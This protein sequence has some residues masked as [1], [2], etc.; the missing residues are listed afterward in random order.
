MLKKII[1]APDSF[2]GTMSSIEVCN[3]IEQG[4]KNINPDIATIKIPIAD[5]GEGTVD[6]FLTAVE[7]KKV[8]VKVKDPLFRD[9]DSFY[10]LLQ[11]GT[12]AVIEMAAASGL[13]LVG[14]DQNPIL[15]S[16]FGTGQLL[17][18]A[19]EHGCTRI[20]I[21]IGGSATNDGGIGAAAALGVKFLDEEGLEIPLNGGGLSRLHRFEISEI[22]PKLKNCEIL[23]ACDVSNPLYG[24][25]GASYVFGPQ[26]GADDVMMKILDENLIHYADVIYKELGIQVGE[27]PG[28]GAAGGLGVALMVFAGAHMKPGIDIIL[29]TVHFEEA[30][31]GADLVI[32]GEGQIDGQSLK[33]KVPVGIAQRASKHHV[34][35]IA[36]V[37][38]IGDDIESIY[39]IGINAVFSTNR[40]SIPFESAKMRC[41][42]DLLKTIESVIRF[43]SIFDV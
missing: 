35:V 37:G 22:N 26:K 3:I 43:A 4:I 12:T 11:D 33:G 15:T 20:I 30:L 23:V 1:I 25:E 40:K 32:T 21:G 10:G 42:N 8:F 34:P 31:C 29:D 17:L 41:R 2:K 24:P 27:F 13:P 14:E 28:T 19:L 39:N 7:G 6:A 36:V 18:D 5:G 38:D 9:I 16:T